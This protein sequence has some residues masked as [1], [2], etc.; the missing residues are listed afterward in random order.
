GKAKSF[1]VVDGV[2]G[3]I[4][5]TYKA[6]NRVFSMARLALIRVVPR[7]V[8]LPSSNPRLAIGLENLPGL[9]ISDLLPSGGVFADGGRLSI[10]DTGMAA[11]LFDRGNFG[12]HR[13]RN[14]FPPRTL[15]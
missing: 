8:G 5:L 12:M 1:G 3:R 2:A 15:R 6:A 13:V 14:V 11:R 9:L 7:V 4:G 10:A